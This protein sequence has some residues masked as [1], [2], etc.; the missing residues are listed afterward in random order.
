MLA[1]CTA[2]FYIHPDTADFLPLEIKTN[3][4]ADLVYTPL[5][6][7]NDWSLAKT[8]FE[9]NEAVY[10]QMFHLSATHAV[11]NAVHEAA[12]RTMADEHP[13]QGYLDQI[14]CMSRGL[15]HIRIE[16]TF[17]SRPG[18]CKLGCWQKRALQSRWSF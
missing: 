4:G 15:H 2:Y 7:A 10:S 11:A 1:S 14:M 8:L 9:T 18:V 12:L 13:L 5:D 6:G 16:L 3:E 17:S